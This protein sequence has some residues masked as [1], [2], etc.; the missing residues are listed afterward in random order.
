MTNCEFVFPMDKPI[1]M[2]DGSSKVWTITDILDILKVHNCSY[3]I[4]PHGADEACSFDHWHVGINTGNSNFKPEAFASWFGLKS[5][6]CEKIKSRF[7][8][9]YL[10]YLIHHNQG[11]KTE[12][13]PDKIIMNFEVDWDKLIKKSDDNARFDSYLASLAR[14]EKSE[15]DLYADF[16]ED[17]LMKHQR[18]INSALVVRSKKMA[19]KKGDKD[20]DVVYITG[21][22]RCGK[23]YFAKKLCEISKM[24]YYDSSNGDH[25]F[26]DYMGEDVVI[27]ND[28]RPSNFKFSELLKILDN[29]MSSRVSA[30]YHNIDLNCKVI[31]LT[32]CTPI[33]D[34]YKELKADVK[35][36]SEQLTGRIKWLYEVHKETIDIKALLSDNKTYK[37]VK[38][39]P[40]PILL[41]DWYGKSVEEQKSVASDMLGSL[42]D[43]LTDIKN[44]ADTHTVEEVRQMTVDDWLDCPFP[45]PQNES[46]GGEK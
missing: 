11:N 40:N 1:T 6:S 23:S 15:H 28:I 8:F 19:I 30:R 37:F 24:S 20:M 13:S 46:A 32:T 44:V 42:I 5:N 3:V 2:A 27:L 7:F 17:I 33:E 10:L 41:E 43:M 18:E 14:G 34:F 21:D 4:A 39:I 12:I 22:A 31:Y 9:G 26:D 25:P 38:T 35:E 16:D 45:A 29:H 36:A